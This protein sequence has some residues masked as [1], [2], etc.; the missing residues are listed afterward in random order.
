[1]S[2][3]PFIAFMDDDAVASPTWLAELLRAFDQ[4]GPSTAIVGGRVNPIWAAPRPPWLHD[5][6][7]GNLSV[8]NWGGDTRP[9]D[10]NEW[11]A[12]TNIA[13]RTQAIREHGGFAT[14]LGRNGPSLSL[15]SNEELHL[16]ERIRASGGQ[17]VYAPRAIVEHLVDPK[18]LTRSWFRKRSAWQAVSDFMM[19]PERTVA[20]TNEHWL[21]TVGYFNSM[22]PHLRTIRGLLDDTNDPE[23]F[24]WQVGAHYAMTAMALSGFEGVDLD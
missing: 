9:A 24:V 23:Q 8:V 18:R 14:Q 22:P 4:F 16:V 15:L 12:G 13:F 5:S 10:A 2:D 11:F 20:K 19:D 6:M 7:L 1:M 21:G 17:L 3:T